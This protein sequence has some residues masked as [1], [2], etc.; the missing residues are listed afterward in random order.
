M[1]PQLSAFILSWLSPRAIKGHW[2]Q[3]ATYSA[4]WNS[5]TFRWLTQEH[6]MKDFT[7]TSVDSKSQK[8]RGE[9]RTSWNSATGLSVVRWLIPASAPVRTHTWALVSRVTWQ[10]VPRG[11]IIQ[12]SS[13]ANSES[14]LPGAHGLPL[15]MNLSSPPL[16]L[17]QAGGTRAFCVLTCLAWAAAALI[18][19]TARRCL[20]APRWKRGDGQGREGSQEFWKSSS[21]PG[22]G[23]FH[24]SNTYLMLSVGQALCQGVPKVVWTSESSGDLLEVAKPRPRGRN[25]L[26]RQHTG[27]FWSSLQVTPMCAQV[28]EQPR[29]ALCW[30]S[31]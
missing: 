1:V 9:L 6:Q 3:Q 17:L 12:V 7:A 11:F 4:S 26:G 8:K 19:I 31:S 16:L 20:H 30:D 22:S 29:H 10:A 21:M 5:N 27:I 2:N 23:C 13:R 15:V 25:T 14:P 28:W 18:G 24:S